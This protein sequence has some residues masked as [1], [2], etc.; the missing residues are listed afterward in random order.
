MIAHFWPMTG[1]VH[2]NPLH[3]LVEH[4]FQDAIRISNRF[5]GGKGYLPNEQYREL[6]KS[7]R[8]WPEH[9]DNAL[10]AFARDDELEVGGRKV[11]HFEVLRAHLLKGITAPP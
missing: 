11:S 10:R 7:G 1:F 9:L 4:P 3:G 2:H 5:T 6:V 8:I